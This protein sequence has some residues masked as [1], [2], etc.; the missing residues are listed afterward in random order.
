[1]VVRRL[2]LWLV[3]KTPWDRRYWVTTHGEGIRVARRFMPFWHDEFVSPY[4]NH[5]RPPWWR[6]FN[7]L[8]HCWRPHGDR[9]EEMHDHRRWSVTICLKGGFWERTPWSFKWH[10]AGSIIFRS[11]RYIH[12]FIVPKETKGKTW[13]LFIVGRMNHGQNTFTVQKH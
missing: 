2:I 10:P 5:N 9:G 4:K 13:T 1:M 11:H 3:R 7:I 8:L 12:S 6:P